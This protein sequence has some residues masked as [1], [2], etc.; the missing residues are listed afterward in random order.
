M[1]PCFVPGVDVDCGNRQLS[2]KYVAGSPT[3]RRLVNTPSTLRRKS[4]E[5][6]KICTLGVLGPS[7]LAPATFRCMCVYTY[8]V[9]GIGSVQF[10]RLPAGDLHIYVVYRSSSGSKRPFS[11]F[12]QVV[13]IFLFSATSPAVACLVFFI[14]RRVQRSL[15]PSM[16]WKCVCTPKPR[17]AAHT[18]KQ[19]RVCGDSFAIFSSSFLGQFLHFFGENSGA[20]GN[21]SFV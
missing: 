1:P 12:D 4:R 3:G 13:S 11:S 15:P 6:K 14:A 16:V 19:T 18:Y 8:L 7:I 20:N 5:E 10:H 9:H 2:T 21:L 17:T